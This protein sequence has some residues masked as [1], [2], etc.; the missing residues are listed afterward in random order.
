[1]RIVMALK[2]CLVVGI[3]RR[4]GISNMNK[5]KTTSNR[6][7]ILRIVIFTMAAVFIFLS[8]AYAH[9]M[10][11]ERLFN[12]FNDFLRDNYDIHQL[13]FSFGTEEELQAY[14]TN[15]I[16]Y[17][18]NRSMFLRRINVT[19][20]TERELELITDDPDVIMEQLRLGTQFVYPFD[21]QEQERY[22]LESLQYIKNLSP[23][24]RIMRISINN[25]NNGASMTFG[26]IYPSPWYGF[27]FE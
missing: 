24:M 1:M 18:L 17:D 19:F 26:G 14:L 27:F 11:S 21:P 8:T 22:L 2:F 16:T 10:V 12:D 5:P 15:I 20:V 13:L 4:R 25:P 6:K 7:K 3:E 23:V 9:Y